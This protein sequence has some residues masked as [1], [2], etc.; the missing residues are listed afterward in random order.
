M[1][2]L[3]PLVILGVG[4]ATVIGLIV[5]LRLNAFIALLIAAIVASLMAPGELPE[6]ISRVAVA[7]GSTAGSIGIVIAL[8][9]VIGKAM[10]DSGAADRIVRGFLS[11]LGEKRSGVALLSSGYVLGIPVFFD[12][13]FYLLVPLARSMYRRTRKNYLL[14]IM[15]IGAGAAVTHTMVPPTPGPL[16][17]AETLEI[18]LGVMILMGAVV[19]LPCGIVGLL[20]A[21]WVDSR[22]PVHLTG[23][24]AGVPQPDFA[25]EPTLPGLIP[26]LLP[27][28]LPVLLISTN[29]LVSSL[30]EVDG[31]APIWARLQPY[32]ALFGDSNLALLISCFIALWLYYD[33]RRPTRD[34]MAAMVEDALMSGGVIILITAAG[35]AFGAMLRAAQI[36]PAI[37]GLFTGGLGGSPVVLLLL[38]FGISSLLK[39]AQGSSTVAM[40]TA[41]AM[42]MAMLT[43]VERLPF[44]MV[45][46]ATAIASGSLV[47]SWMNDSGFWIYTKMGGL[48][49]VQ[50]LKSWTTLLMVLG[51]TG[52]A[53][54]LV[55]AL[56]FPL[57]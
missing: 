9:A 14:Y 35:G 40:I 2:D 42:M 27:I 34:E 30:A 45:Y 32:A 51:F 10:M 41:S 22:M 11:L 28:A 53:V 21:G 54:T 29:T 13:V 56:L 7:F 43:E 24:E 23:D 38:G 12:T 5:G 6:K 49:V 36:G 33:Q 17:L 15:A 3:Y 1:T 44:H 37:E 16:V 57:V 50:G 18:D 47:I 39:I 19:A 46:L 48:T 55:L 26:S 25:P 4:M 52:L 8:A 31:A 20:Y